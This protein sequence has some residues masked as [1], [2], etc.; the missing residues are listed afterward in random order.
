MQAV[1]V[2][3]RHVRLHRARAYVPH[4]VRHATPMCNVRRVACSPT[5]P[6]A[7][8]H[9]EAT[10]ALARARVM[11]VCVVRRARAYVPR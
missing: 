6:H 5:A 2:R 10:S 1:R 8:C 7:A 4:Y 11:H 3:S 9:V